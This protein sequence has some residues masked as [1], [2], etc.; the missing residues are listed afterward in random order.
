MRSACRARGGRSAAVWCFMPPDVSHAHAIRT[1]NGERGQNTSA[2]DKLS[3]L[4][5]CTYRILLCRLPG[6][7]RVGTVRSLAQHAHQ[8]LEEEVCQK[9][10]GEVPCAYRSDTNLHRM[11]GVWRRARAGRQEVSTTGRGEGSS[12][13]PEGTVQRCTLAR[14]S[15]AASRMS[16][17]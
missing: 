5:N 15:L 12:T 14:T 8:V 3:T 13:A 2:H 16:F 7:C 10:C 1:A 17:P 9:Q 11:A 4:Q 6:C